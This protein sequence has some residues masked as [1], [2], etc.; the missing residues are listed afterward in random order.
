MPFVF[1]VT[2]F[3]YSSVRGLRLRTVLR[4]Y[5]STLRR[6][7]NS[8]C[9]TITDQPGGVNDDPPMLG[10]RPGQ[11]I[12]SVVSGWWTYEGDGPSGGRPSSESSR[13]RRRRAKDQC[14]RRTNAMIATGRGSTAPPQG[15]DGTPMGR[16]RCARAT[17]PCVR[18]LLCHRSSLG[19]MASRALAESEG[20]VDCLDWGW[21]VTVTPIALLP[22][23][24]PTM[25]PIRMT[26]RMTTTMNNDK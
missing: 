25:L 8:V 26:T 14:A 2:Y 3:R 1:V 9:M 23:I 7:L 18:P 11:F 16:E 6:C 12:N 20:A 19:E 21:G 5:V 15:A 22:L 17:V 4:R 13:M 24:L 10:M